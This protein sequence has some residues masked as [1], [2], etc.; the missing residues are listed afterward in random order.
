MLTQRWA[1]RYQPRVVHCC[2]DAGGELLSCWQDDMMCAHAPV[3]SRALA[4]FVRSFAESCCGC[5]GV[6]N[7]MPLMRCS[8]YC[9]VMQLPTVVFVG[10]NNSFPNCS[11]I[12]GRHLVKHTTGKLLGVCTHSSDVVIINRCAYIIIN[13]NMY[14]ATAGALD[15]A[16]K[17]PLLLC[18]AVWRS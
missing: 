1:Q 8:R 5:T 11:L 16:W 2:D 15:G 7:E 17:A 4:T 3:L 13:Y 9:V 6:P 12:L 18:F 10:H 14:C